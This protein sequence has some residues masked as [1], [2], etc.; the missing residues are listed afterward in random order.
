MRNT[1]GSEL[2][3]KLWRECPIDAVKWREMNYQWQRRVFKQ[4]YGIDDAE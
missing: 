4:M 3:G 1:V 2:L